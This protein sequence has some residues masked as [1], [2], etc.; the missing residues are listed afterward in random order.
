M[1]GAAAEAAGKGLA[2]FG[3]RAMKMLKL[4]L[5]K[6]LPEAARERAAAT[7]AAGKII[8]AAGVSVAAR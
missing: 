3:R 1:V 2:G 5:R 7:E 4:S 8:G 6:S